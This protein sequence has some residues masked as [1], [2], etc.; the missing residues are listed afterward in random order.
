MVSL[1][2]KQPTG[3]TLVVTYSLFAL[4]AIV[5]NL[6]AQHLTISLMSHLSLGVRAIHLPLLFEGPWNMLVGMLVGT[7]VGL[8]VKY[9]LDKRYI[10]DYE[11]KDLKSDG[12]AFI[13]YSAMGLVTTAIFYATQ[14]I[15]FKL[16]KTQ[17]AFYIGGAIGLSIGYW[18]KYEL[19]KR[20]V[21]IDD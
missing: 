17:I 5:V 18:V 7:L 9:L 10:F 8:M 19:D 21:F 11:P 4:V 14:L 6:G 20:F 2:P 3:I 1:T 13:L 15:F 16:F 12:V